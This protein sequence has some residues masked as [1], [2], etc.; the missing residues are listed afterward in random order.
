ML[1]PTTE[2]YFFD[3]SNKEEEQ[4]FYQAVFGGCETHRNRWDR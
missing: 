1:E 2:A 4:R 3:I